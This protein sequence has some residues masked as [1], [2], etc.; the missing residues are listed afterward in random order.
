MTRKEMRRLAK[1]QGFWLMF[2]STGKYVS[3]TGIKEAFCVFSGTVPN[4]VKRLK[5]TNA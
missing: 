1:K 5:M 3:A 4:L 2:D